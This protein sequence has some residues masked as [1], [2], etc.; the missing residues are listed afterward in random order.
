MPRLKFERTGEDPVTGEAL[1]RLQ[2]EGR[3]VREGLTIDQVIEAITAQDEE[4]LG[5]EHGPDGPAEDPRGNPAD[6]RR[7]S[8]REPGWRR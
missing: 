2:I 7:K 4:R 5:I 1:Y 8:C 3:T 6:G